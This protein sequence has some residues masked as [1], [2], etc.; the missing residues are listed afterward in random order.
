M[1]TTLYILGGICVTAILAHVFFNA[2]RGR[3]HP[4]LIANATLLGAYRSLLAFVGFPIVIVGGIYTYQRLAEQLARPDL[5]LTFSGPKMAN[6]SV[7]NVSETVVR[8]P[9]YSVVLFNVD[10]KDDP[11]NPLPIPTELGDYIR[12][13]ERWGP[14]QMI[15]RPQVVARI[16]N[17]DELCGWA[18][19]TCPECPRHSY[20]VFIRHGESGW[21]AEMGDNEFPDMT[22]IAALLKDPQAFR[23]AFLN[24][25]PEARRTF[26]AVNAHSPDALPRALAK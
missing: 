10:A 22:K 9:K 11:R 16:E 7:W 4:W 20:W 5:A 23:K 13:G 3:L 12:P 17:G 18:H 19:A 15:S 14:N 6:V 8:D 26:L 25:V 24:T 2:F 21:F 1:I